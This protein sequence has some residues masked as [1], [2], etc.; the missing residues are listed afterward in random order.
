MP[1]PP[2][3]NAI[4][5]SDI[6]EIKRLLPTVDV[7]Q[8]YGDYSS[9]ALYKAISG[10]GFSPLPIIHLLLCAGADPRQGLGDGNVLH[11]L[12]F[13]NYHHVA[14]KD[15]AE[16]VGLLVEKG[17]NLEQRSG[18]F[19][20]T[21]LHYAIDEWEPKQVE[22]LL[23]SGADPNATIGLES[24]AKG[25]EGRD[26]FFVATNNLEMFALLLKYGGDPKCPDA[27]RETPLERLAKLIETYPDGRYREHL[28]KAKKLLDEAVS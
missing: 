28:L 3:L 11:G 2:I 14:L 25:H 22:A 9:T 7:N 21:P 18:S 23:M 24:T 12:G 20:W 19:Q 8:R 26:C 5:D 15:L 10:I 27:F 16:T 13:G 17:A 4:E 6:D 1:S